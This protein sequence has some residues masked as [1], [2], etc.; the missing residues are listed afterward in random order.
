M[1]N[2]HKVRGNGAR[3]L[4]TM[5]EKVRGHC[6]SARNRRAALSVLDIELWQGRY[7]AKRF[8]LCPVRRAIKSGAVF[9]SMLAEK[10]PAALPITEYIHAWQ[11]ILELAGIKQEAGFTRFSD[12]ITLLNGNLCQKAIAQFANSRNIM[13]RFTF[14]A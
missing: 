6:P 5:A 8:Y 9:R 10:P 7:R 14:V 1:S 12:S 11:G 4:P 13:R 3:V 2:F